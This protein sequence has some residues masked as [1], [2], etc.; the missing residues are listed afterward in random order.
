MFGSSSLVPVG[1]AVELVLWEDTDGDG[2]ATGSVVRH[3]EWVTVQAVDDVTWSSYTLASPVR[4]DGPGDIWV[5]M[6]DRF[7]TSGEGSVWPACMDQTTSAQ[8]SWAGWDTG[9]VTPDPPVIP[10]TDTWTLIDMYFAGNWML[11]AHGHLCDGGAGAAG[12]GT[13]AGTAGVA[14]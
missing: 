9:Y 11:R 2:D 6:V 13:V 4:F 7:S 5:G 8:R 14:P 3:Y 10:T 12:A 1:A